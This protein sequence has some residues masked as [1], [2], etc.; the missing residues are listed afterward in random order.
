M[1]AQQSNR[2]LCDGQGI[3][4]VDATFGKCRGM[5]FFA[6]VANLEHRAGDDGGIDHVKRGRVDHHGGMHPFVA[7]PFEQEDFAAAVASFFCWR[8]DNTDGEADIVGDFSGGDGSANRHRGDEVVTT[9]VTDARETIVLGTDAN[10]ERA[11]AGTGNKRGGQIADPS[12]HGESGVR[13]HVGKPGRG[14]LFFKAELGIRVNPMAEGDQAVLSGC[15]RSR[16][17]ALA[18]MVSSLCSYM[19]S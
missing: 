10:V 7:A 15:K 11:V 16:A 5:G 3:G 1:L 6:G 2:G 8:T 18:S 19:L 14:F 12:L 13:Q 4:G 17:P 9:G